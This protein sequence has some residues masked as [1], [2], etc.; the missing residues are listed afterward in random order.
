MIFTITGTN[1]FSPSNKGIRASSILNTL[2][3]S[4][5]LVAVNRGEVI[6]LREP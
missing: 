5:D 2:G 1:A 3:E 4:G 6:T